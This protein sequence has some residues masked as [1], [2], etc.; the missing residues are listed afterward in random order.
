MPRYIAYCRKSRDEADKQVLSIEA[1]IAEITE[2][3]QREHLDIVEFVTESKTAKCPGR[4][5]FGEVIKK[6]EHGVAD[7]IIAWHADRLARNSVDGGRLIYLLDT[8]KL[9][10]L[11]FPTLWFENTPQ[12]KF[13]LSIAFGQS[14]YYVDNLSENVK[15]GLRQKIRNG[16]WPGKAPYGY[17]NNPRTRGIDL[18]PVQSRA[19]KRTFQLF[20][21]GGST[22]TDLA[23]YLKKFGLTRK[24]GKPLHIAEIRQILA[25]KFYIG[26]MHYQNEYSEGSHEQF[27]SK[28]LFKQ[29]QAELARRSRTQQKSHRFDFVGLAKCGHCGASITA[30]EHTKVYKTT[31]RRATYIYYRCTR[32]MGKCDQPAVT[33]TDLETQLRQVATDVAIPQSWGDKWQSL[34]SEDEQQAKLES[35]ANVATLERKVSGIDQKLNTLLDSYLES[36]VDPATYKLKKNELSETKQ[37]LVEQI[38][39]IKD[40]GAE[41]IEPMRE[42][43]MC[44]MQSH[45]IARAKN[46]GEELSLFAKRV[47]LNFFLT[48]RRLSSELKMGYTALQAGRGAWRADLSPD[49]LSFC[50]GVPRLELGTSASQ[51]RRSTI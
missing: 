34:L 10:D 45:K 13:M 25:N 42:L 6:I 26:V 22:F 15:R 50:V 5:K 31:G 28:S 46:N 12:G 3:A 37:K 43:I 27:I 23:R 47:G 4:E 9:V 7:G 21:S 35:V 30:E 24:N 18:E 29:A 14:K 38:T 48:D 49:N 51:T 44:A 16:V 11:K 40:K 8:G 39:E 33:H 17:V 1:Q 32:K 20:A 41:W 19:I 36:V 2:F